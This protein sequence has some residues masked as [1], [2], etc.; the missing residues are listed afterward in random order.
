MKKSVL[1]FFSLFLLCSCVRENRI[2]TY[3]SLKYSTL[4]PNSL[5][6]LEEWSGSPKIIVG[7][8][9]DELAK[10]QAENGYKPIGRSAFSWDD[11]PTKQEIL[12]A[13]IRARADVVL[14][15]R[16][17]MYSRNG[18]QYV[19]D[20]Q[21]GKTETTETRG[22]ISGPLNATYSQKS[23]TRTPDT[24]RHT[25]IPYERHVFRF[26]F[27][28][29]RKSKPDTVGL[30]LIDVDEETQR[31]IG[32]R[33]GAKV[34]SVLRDGPAYKA[35]I[36]PDDIVISIGKDEIFGKKSQ[37][38]F[39]KYAEKT[40]IIKIIRDEKEIEKDI[41]LNPLPK[42]DHFDVNGDLILP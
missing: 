18:I 40:T 2:I 37:E 28:F 15:S 5:G 31:K 34:L 22:R 23:T 26:L 1:L 21:P 41:T 17:Y 10:K 8:D 36:F 12:E 14:C 19:P 27:S 33:T 35:N 29:W 6:C 11:T 3:Q 20:Y 7:D 39:D 16:E 38:T 42:L 25:Y 13:A 24:L 32:K 30:Y 9:H 4:S